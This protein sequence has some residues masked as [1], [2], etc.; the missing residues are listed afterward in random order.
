MNL[1]IRFLLLVCFFVFFQL[2]TVDALHS[3]GKQLCLLHNLPH[4]GLGILYA[5]H[6]MQPQR[7]DWERDYLLECLIVQDEKRMAEGSRRPV[8]AEQAIQ[9]WAEHPDKQTKDLASMAWQQEMDRRKLVESQ[10]VKEKP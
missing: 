9:M 3:L 5:A 2:Q 7:K 6:V 10:K 4:R 1:I 8:I